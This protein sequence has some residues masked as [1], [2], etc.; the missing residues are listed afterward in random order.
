MKKD[1]HVVRFAIIGLGK[2]TTE[3]HIPAI[4][5]SPHCELVS[6]CDANP[7]RVSE[8]SSKYNVPGTV[9]VDRLIE[10]NSF[11]AA[12]VA[13][14]H[15]AYIDIIRKLAKAGKHII[16]E[17][18][19]AITIAEV[20]ETLRILKQHK[21][22]FGVMTQRR[23]NPIYRAFPQLMRYI[24]K[25]YSIEGRYTMNI[26]NLGEGWRAQ[27][28]L[29][30]GGALIDMGYHYIDLLV[31]YFGL[32]NRLSAFITTKN[33]I[34]QLYDVEDTARL[35]FEYDNEGAYDEK[36][37][38]SLLVSRAYPEKQ[39]YLRV[40]GTA[41]TVELSRG[42]VRRLDLAGNEVERLERKEGW[43]SA[44]AEQLD[45][46][47]YRILSF[48]PFLGQEYRNHFEHVAFIEAAYRSDQTGM[49]QRP[50]QLFNEMREMEQRIYAA[51]EVVYG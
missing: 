28:S 29:A 19:F 22:Y 10:K 37:V 39:E 14:P 36:L 44:I 8:I 25:P 45:F 50:I 3:D 1:E 17:K 2:Q 40:L 33:R 16:K 6:V 5:Q 18:P 26:Q 9:S 49:L 38:G 4:I 27:K 32:P 21:V 15:T 51:K 34:D 13:V 46:F 41:G 48:G 12:I 24:G 20:E 11:D 42:V 31:W 43:P 7:E 35:L 47:V 23:F 30:G